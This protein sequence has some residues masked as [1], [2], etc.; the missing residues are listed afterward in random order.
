VLEAD[1]TQDSSDAYGRLLRYVE[2]QGRDVG[3]AQIRSGS[4]EA[5]E[6][7]PHVRRLDDYLAT[8]AAAQEPGRGR[9]SACS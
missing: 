3:L 9:W 1:P 5:S 8:Q 4:A 2:V 7:Y 6:D